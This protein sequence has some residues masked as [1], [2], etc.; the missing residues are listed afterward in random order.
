MPLPATRT[1]KIA[2]DRAGR[3]ASRD[4]SALHTRAHAST[5]EHNLYG[6]ACSPLQRHPITPTVRPCSARCCNAIDRHV[7]TPARRRSPSQACPCPPYTL[8]APVGA[9]GMMGINTLHLVGSGRG[10]HDWHDSSIHRHAGREQRR[11]VGNRNRRLRGGGCD[12]HGDHGDGHRAR[13]PG[14]AGAAGGGHVHWH[15]GGRARHHDVRVRVVAI[16]HA[17]LD[18]LVDGVEVRRAYGGRGMRQGAE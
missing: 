16:V 5:H 12:G 7:S 9:V 4:T 1:R 14:G 11:V 18:A 6:R 15:G 13:R 17:A 10:G 8:I 2:S 3:Q